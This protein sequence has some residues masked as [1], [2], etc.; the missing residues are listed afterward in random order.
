MRRAYVVFEGG[1]AKGVAHVGALNAIERTDYVAEGYAGTSAGAVVAALAAAGF[2]ADEIIAA[3]SRRTILDA[4]P[5]GCPSTVAAL[6]G[7]G[8][9]YIRFL[10][11]LSKRPGEVKLLG[12]VLAAIWIGAIVTAFWIHVLAGIAAL[13]VLIC[14]TAAAALHFARGMARLDCIRDCLGRLLSDKIGKQ[15]IEEGALFRDFGPGTGRPSLKIVATNLSRGE[16]DVFSPEHTPDVPVADAVAASICIPM[17]FRPWQPKIGINAAHRRDEVYLDGGL[18]SN[19][20]A[21]VFDDELAIDRHATVLAA[22]IAD[23]AD[24]E[25]PRGRVGWA[26]R[27]VR[28]AIFGARTLSTRNVPNLISIPLDVS[29]GLLDFDARADVMRDT[30]RQSRRQTE[31][32]LLHEDVRD[33]LPAKIHKGIVRGLLDIVDAF[34]DIEQQER[35]AMR[36]AISRTRIRV[37]MANVSEIARFLDHPQK[38]GSARPDAAIR[39][40]YQHGFSETKDERIA[41]SLRRSIVGAAVLR[42]AGNGA[43]HSVWE[44]KTRREGLFDGPYLNDDRDAWARKMVDRDVDW[45]W[46]V[47]IMN[48]EKDISFRGDQMNSYAVAVDGDRPLPFPPRLMERILNLLSQRIDTTVRQAFATKRR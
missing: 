18:L 30:V 7:P 9:R 23:A 41:L 6:I 39:L 40:V 31:F 32:V 46:A 10:R 20:P 36:S 25:T 17:V 19:L 12:G 28:T 2:R 47:P 37:A 15:D 11:R 33:G 27:A 42:G 5:E 26:V 22:E 1:G 14:G 45:V 3:K 48:A 24:L 13:L 29:I 34:D 8:W 21:W 35:D 38:E 4:L 43:A 16:L 44:F